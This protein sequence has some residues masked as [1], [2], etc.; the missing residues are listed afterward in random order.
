V[1]APLAI[2]HQSLKPSWDLGQ[3]SYYLFF[4]PFWDTNV[5]NDFRSA[6]CHKIVAQDDNDCIILHS[7]SLKVGLSLFQEFHTSK[8]V[9]A[10]NI[11][12]KYRMVD[13]ENVGVTE[14]IYAPISKR[15]VK[16]LNNFDGKESSNTLPKPPIW[17]EDK[18]I[19]VDDA[20]H[21]A[22]CVQ[23]IFKLSKVIIKRRKIQNLTSGKGIEIIDNQVD[24]ESVQYQVLL[25]NTSEKSESDYENIDSIIKIVHV[26]KAL[27]FCDGMTG[28]TLGESLKNGIYGIVCWLCCTVVYGRQ[29][30][31]KEAN[32]AV[33][34]DKQCTTLPLSY[35]SL[36]QLH[37]NN[38][39]SL[40]KNQ[41]S[42]VECGV[43]VCQ[44]DH[45]SIK[46]IPEVLFILKMLA[47]NKGSISLSESLNY[48]L[49]VMH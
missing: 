32:K 3:P 43:R 41:P 42:D 37:V 16:R 21:F 11:P 26:W 49:L 22:A 9:R 7:S 14:S 31:E 2:L 35:F 18:C 23:R 25:S 38:S 40:F 1:T 8:H 20:F 30:L 36:F 29:K 44:D 6:Q 33:L 12:F 28:M 47:K 13:Y 39:L 24:G 27:S 5:V 34:Y 48:L 4:I 17:P 10:F 19:S 15:K 45:N 46:S